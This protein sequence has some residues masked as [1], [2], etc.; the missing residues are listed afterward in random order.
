MS[1]VFI[2][3][4]QH[5]T[6]EASFS[7]SR[8]I[9]SMIEDNIELNKFTKGDFELAVNFATSA[10]SLAIIND[11]VI[12]SLLVKKIAKELKQEANKSQKQSEIMLMSLVKLKNKLY[13]NVYRIIA[14]YDATF[15]DGKP[16]LK[17]T[18]GQDMPS[19]HFTKHYRKALFGKQKYGWVK[20][21]DL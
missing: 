7:M 2:N 10:W 18:F 8:A 11:D 19:D 14:D 16:Y 1:K 17:V 9:M 20:N 5:L 12:I 6:A 13:G 21:E 15:K 3:K 4:Y